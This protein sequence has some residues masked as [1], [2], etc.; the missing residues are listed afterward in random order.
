MV[1]QK[2]FYIYYL[3]E[4]LFAEHSTCPL[5]HGTGKSGQA[6]GQNTK[7]M[8]WRTLKCYVELRGVR[9]F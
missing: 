4:K 8:S 5:L 1:D 7:T 6:A 2:C 3:F 9:F